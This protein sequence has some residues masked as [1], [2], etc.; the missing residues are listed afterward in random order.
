MFACFFFYLSG[1]RL[2][3]LIV[4]RSWRTFQAL[5]LETWGPKP[6]LSSRHLGSWTFRDRY[7]LHLLL[8]ENRWFSFF[9][10]L[11]TCNSVVIVTQV[12]VIPHKRHF[13]HTIHVFSPPFE[14]QGWSS[15]VFKQL[16]ECTITMDICFFQMR[17]IGWYISASLI[18]KL[19]YF[20]C[21]LIQFIL[22]VFIYLFII[23]FIITK[24]L[25]FSQFT[26]ISLGIIMQNALE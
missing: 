11:T 24:F 26:Y 4:F 5:W 9:A 19:N 8:T 17:N 7:D 25:N 15:S 16:A 3:L 2:V 22:Y 20:Y 23:I 1:Y 14:W 18:T 21:L 13:I 6:T 10:E 12:K